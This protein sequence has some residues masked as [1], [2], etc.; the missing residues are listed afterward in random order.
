MHLGDMRRHTTR[1]LLPL[2]LALA[3][4]VACAT[5]PDDRVLQLLV[6]TD[7]ALYSLATDNAAAVTLVN[8][9]TMSIY[10]PMNEYVYVQRFQ[11][12]EWW[13]PMPWFFVD[14]ATPSFPVVPGDSLVAWPMDFDY[15]GRRPA[16]YRFLFEVALDPHGRRLVPEQDRVSKP[17]ELRP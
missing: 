11:D 8:Q 15:V 14:G 16:I 13:E 7:K 2:P 3:G 6:R 9:G 5:G 4:A 10:A 17:F 12:G 1:A